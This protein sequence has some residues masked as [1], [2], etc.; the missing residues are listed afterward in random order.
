MRLFT[1]VAVLLAL[2]CATVLAGCGRKSAEDVGNQSG[3]GVT[4]SE[5]QKLGPAGVRAKMMEKGQPA[6]G[7]GNQGTAKAPSGGGEAK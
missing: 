1:T 3:R 5:S 2:V 4:L 6:G 7:V